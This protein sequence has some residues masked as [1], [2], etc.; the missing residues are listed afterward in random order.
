MLLGV[1]EFL[2]CGDVFAAVLF[3]ED[4]ESDTFAVG[5][6]GEVRWCLAAPMGRGRALC[7][8]ERCLVA[9]GCGGG[10]EGL[11]NAQGSALEGFGQA[12]GLRLLLEGGHDSMAFGESGR[13]RERGEFREAPGRDVDQLDLVAAV[14][15]V[16]V[17]FLRVG[18][19]AGLAGGVDP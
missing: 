19:L 5:G 9:L 16:S 10:D 13:H 4:E 12:H 14:G 15:A 7:G 11:D 1:G 2:V 18:D 3:L 17:D 8:S 6:D